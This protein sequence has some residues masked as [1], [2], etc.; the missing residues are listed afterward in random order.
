MVSDF[1]SL[2]IF[3]VPD[4]MSETVALLVDDDFVLGNLGLPEGEG[5]LDMVDARVHLV[6]TGSE[7]WIFVLIINLRGGIMIFIGKR[8]IRKSRHE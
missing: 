8:A 7:G 3:E 6:W 5:T 4:W 1:N 2:S